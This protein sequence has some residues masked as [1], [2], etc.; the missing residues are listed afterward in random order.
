MRNHPIRYSETALGDVKAPPRLGEDTRDILSRV[1][2]LE[3]AEIDR[4]V[5]AGVV[6]E[7]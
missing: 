1:G 6:E 3:A 4:L 7:R 5:G 2:G